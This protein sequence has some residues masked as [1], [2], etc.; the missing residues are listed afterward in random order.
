[1][2]QAVLEFFSKLN[3]LEELIRWGG[4]SV[5][6]FIVI[7]ETGLFF[8][9]LLPGDSFLLTAG[10]FAASVAFDFGPTFFSIFTLAIMGYW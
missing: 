7:A 9:F 10:L 1:M 2:F 3:N 4:Y 8:G 6:A 5:L